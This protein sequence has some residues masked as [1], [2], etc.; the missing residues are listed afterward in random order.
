MTALPLVDVGTITRRTQVVELPKDGEL[1][2]Q[3]LLAADEPV[4]LRGRA[5]DWPLAMAGL[6]GPRQTVDY[7]K[8][9]D[10][11]RPV[12]AYVGAPEIKGRYFYQ[13]DLTGLNFEGQKVSLSACLDAVIDLLDAENAPSIY[14]GSTDLD[15]YLP[16]LRA[17]NDLAFP[18]PAP[19]ADP[20]VAS[21]W[22][23]N[24]TT[25]ATHFD[26]S[27]N[28]ACCLVGKRRFTLFPPDQIANLYPGPLAPTPGGQIV[29]LVDPAAPDLDR[30]PRYA[31]AAEAGQ[32]ADL[33]PGDVLFYPAMW[34]HNVEALE[35]FNAMV[36]YWWNTAPAFMDTP[37]ATL[38]HGLLSLRGRSEQEKAA[39]RG[40]FEFYVFGASD[41]ASAHLPEPTR[42]D[43]GP[44]DELSARRL[45]ARVLQKLNR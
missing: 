14:V 29:S 38:E 1:P 40:L 8:R 33:E 23:G 21:I 35:P 36:N 42:G 39:W 3:S 43:L 34:W 18:A 6:E 37:M 44:L 13:N 30:Y 27:N 22:L 12:V 9:F 4:I 32:I 11:G 2:L 25:A 20:P 17:E 15:T 45:R 26:M 28:L 24:R 31:V 41:Q 19:G 16:G 7:L 5:K 10:A